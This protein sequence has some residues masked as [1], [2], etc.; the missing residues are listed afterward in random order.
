[1][2]NG[3]LLALGV[4]FL[5]VGCQSK[6]EICAQWEAASIRFRATEP[7]AQDY[8]RKLGIRTPYGERNYQAAESVRNFCEFYKG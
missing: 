2:K 6:K 7:N 5:L 3:L 4:G 1:M 8:R